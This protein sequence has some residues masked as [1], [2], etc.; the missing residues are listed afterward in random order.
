MQY[1]DFVNPRYYVNLCIIALVYLVACEPVS[2]Y[3][4]PQQKALNADAFSVVSEPVD[5]Q[6]TEEFSIIDDEEND[7]CTRLPVNFYNTVSV[8]ASK[9]MPVRNLI[10]KIAT[11][12]GISVIFSPEVDGVIEC[13][14]KNRKFIDALLDICSMSG[15][16]YIINGDMVRIEQDSPILKT[17]NVQFLNIKRD[18]HTS[19]SISTDVF[20]ESSLQEN[21]DSNKNG[22]ASFVS[23]TLQNDFWG[24]LEK[25]LSMLVGDDGYVSIHKQ[26]G[27][28]SIQT[29]QQ[30]HDVIQKFLKKLK[31]TCESQ[32]LIEAKILEIELSDEFRAGINWDILKNSG[33]KVNK[34]FDS[35]G[36]FAIGGYQNNQKLNLNVIAGL[37]EKF[38]AVKTLSSPRITVLNNQSAILKVA[39]NEVIYLPSLQ[40]QYAN[41]TSNN[42]NMDYMSTTLHTIPVGLILSVIPSIDLKTNT[43]ILDLRPT[44]SKISRYKEVPFFY[45]ANQAP[46]NQ[47]IPIIDVREMD[48]VIKLKSGQVAVMGGLMQE[49]SGNNRSGLPEASELD[50]LFGDR[51]KTT[52][53]TE[54]VIFLKAT[55][56]NKKMHHKAD[57]KI[58]EKFA[59]DPRPLFNNNKK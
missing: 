34:S 18:M 47:K 59:N 3:H 58:Y 15:L 48:S 11:E 50:L 39:K 20:S 53:V 31:R 16:K 38:G 12:A 14:F 6:F 35:S 57:Q 43:V 19:V 42:N 29:T 27:L 23:G 24:E 33:L 41:I 17:Y 1:I 37:I 30:K 9:E 56:V 26:S 52:N 28:I 22:S 4:M 49:N 44:I 10:K 25:N 13:A 5:D 40:R 46:H 51:E 7:E 21:K 32:V 45:A 8:L 2:K 36:T 54:L 55:I